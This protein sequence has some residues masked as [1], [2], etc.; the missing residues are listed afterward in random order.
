MQPL[1]KLS[2]YDNF[3]LFW[4]FDKSLIRI[5]NAIANVKMIKISHFFMF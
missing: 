3:L 5:L 4:Q 2:T 1:G